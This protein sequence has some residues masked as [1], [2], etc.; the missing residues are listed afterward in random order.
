MFSPEYPGTHSVVNSRLAGN[1]EICLSLPPEDW[2]NK[3]CVCACG[4]V[5]VY[6]CVCACCGWVSVPWKTEEGIR[7][8]G[9]VVTGH[10]ELQNVSTRTEFKFYAEAG[11]SLNH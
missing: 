8:S 6:A 11:R 4:C 7:F 2:E 5:P 10:W 9:A 1:S 3:V